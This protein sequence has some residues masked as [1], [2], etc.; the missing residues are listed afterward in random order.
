MYLPAGAF[1]IGYLD[2]SRCT[3]RPRLPLFKICARLHRPGCADQAAIAANLDVAGEPD[4][5]PPRQAVATLFF[6][7]S[8]T[9]QHQLAWEVLVI[10][11]GWPF[12][13]QPADWPAPSAGTSPH[14]VADRAHAGAGRA[15]RNGETVR[16]VVRPGRTVKTLAV[17]QQAVQATGLLLGHSYQ[18][19]ARFRLTARVEKL[20]APTIDW[21]PTANAGRD[22][23]AVALPG[24]H[25]PP[26]PVLHR[27]QCALWDAVPGSRS[28]ACCAWCRG[29]P[30]QAG[31]LGL[32]A[33]RFAAVR[34]RPGARRMCLAMVS[35]R[36]AARR[37]LL[38]A[39]QQPRRRGG[40]ST[41]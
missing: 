38:P 22:G 34:S 39:T 19:A 24:R 8:E 28:P 6:H 5:L 33:G 41:L 20:V 11:P 7:N 31:E 36:P 26:D 37:A 3:S 16:E 9:R 18:I 17:P 15:A 4:V 40:T 35:P 2:H 13:R 21:Q 27:A 10:D 1:P 12:C 14:A 32:P 23:N 25:G 30:E 29:S